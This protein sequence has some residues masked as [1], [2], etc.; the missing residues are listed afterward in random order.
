[1]G[2]SCC[3]SPC[4]KIDN[5][6]NNCMFMPPNVNLD[7][8][9]I[10]GSDPHTNL[11][12]IDNNDEKISFY[13]VNNNYNTRKWIVFSHGNAA[14]IFD[15]YYYAKRLSTVLSVNCIF[16]DYPGYGFSTGTPTE[17]ACIETLEQII[18]HMMITMKIPMNDIILIGQSIG[19]G[20]TVSYAHKHHWL[21]PIILISP[22]KT[23]V[24]IITES[25]S[26]IT[27]YVDK[28]MSLKNIA[29]MDCPVKIFH[30][31]KDNVIPIS[32][33]KALAAARKNKTFEPVWLDG[34]GHNDILDNIS[35]K[36]LAE[37]I[38]YEN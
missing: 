34:I 27:Q 18:S 8:I 23:I 37:V 15:Y 38:N 9:P 24:S 33:G 11:N 30:G 4:Q 10:I 12:T 25:S 16:Y 32:H 35:M 6:M 28:F 21:S 36:D 26:F 31:T 20:V 5:F 19:T 1:M 17:E 14:T 3:T 29:E 2:A 22:Y 7:I 13:S